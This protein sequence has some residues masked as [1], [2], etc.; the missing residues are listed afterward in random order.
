MKEFM[1]WLNKASGDDPQG[2][3]KKIGQAMA[4]LNAANTQ[5]ERQNAAKAIADSI[6]GLP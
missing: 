5:E 3:V 1:A 2:Y 6:S 4:Q